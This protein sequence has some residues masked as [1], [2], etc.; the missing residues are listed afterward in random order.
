MPTTEHTINDAL[1]AVLRGT[2]LAW[3]EVNVVSSEN[4]GML[5]G[6]SKRPDILVTEANVSPVVIEIEVLPA[7]TVERDAINRL[8]EKVRATGQTILSSIAVRLPQKLRTVS[9][10][11]L[12]TEIA[13]ASDLD[14]ALYTG[15]TAATSKRWP[16]SGWI[17]GKCR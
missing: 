13:E 4:T 12:Q 16:S 14:I 1:A 7:T 5:K 8:S 3:R 10:A 15:S 17:R 11:K 6:S 9:P 2:R